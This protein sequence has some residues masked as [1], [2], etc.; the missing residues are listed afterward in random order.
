MS[1]PGDSGSS[2]RP[3]HSDAGLVWSGA[4]LPEASLAVVLLHGRGGTAAGMQ[5][6]AESIGYNGV[7]YAAPQAAGGT[8]YPASFMADGEQNSAGVESAHRVIASVLDG[9]AA[10]GLNAERC[11][12]L[13]FSQGACLAADHAY[14]FP[15]RYGFVAALTGGLIG[16][17]GTAFPAAGSLSGTPVFLGSSR[18]DPHVPWDRVE[19]TA[20]TLRSMGGRVRLEAYDRAPHAV[21]P[22]Q[23]DAVRS[24]IDGAFEDAW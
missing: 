8:W 7:A 10:A 5:A 14:R 20:G 1:E 21:L 9:L 2:F 18:P 6:L 22:Q 16:P 24:L 17:P 12:L 23:V 4:G 13:G 15:R 11:G 19:E 3:P